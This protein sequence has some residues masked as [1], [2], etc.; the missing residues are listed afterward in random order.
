MLKTVQTLH[1]GM[2]LIRLHFILL[3]KSA[4]VKGTYAQ[5]IVQE[6][7]FSDYL[8][9]ECYFSISCTLCTINL[10]GLSYKQDKVGKS[11]PSLSP[12]IISSLTNLSLT[13]NQQTL[14]LET[15]RTQLGDYLKGERCWNLTPAKSVSRKGIEG[16]KPEDWW[17]FN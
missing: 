11:L 10:K 9:V 12:Q 14:A 6:I 17:L 4:G 16:R 1:L 2:C 15:S 13:K 7:F 5:H 8:L 3:L